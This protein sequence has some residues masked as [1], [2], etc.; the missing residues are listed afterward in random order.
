M[1]ICVYGAASTKIDKK[2]TRATEDL[3]E[4]LALR[5]HTLVFG[6]GDGGVMGAAARG[7]R[8][9]G[10]TVMGVAP[11]FFTNG[12]IEEIYP[13][14]DALVKTDS[15]GTRKTVME[16]NADAFITG[17]GG[18]GTYD[19]FFQVLTLKQLKVFDK[20]IIIFNVAHFYDPIVDLLKKGI[21]EKF[22]RSD[23]LS[24]YKVFTERQM[25]AMAE[26][27]EAYD[28]DYTIANGECVD[29]IYGDK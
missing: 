29:S 7:F 10:G 1:R 3:C 21:E 27:I 5:G 25:D 12:T 20:P 19:E 2:Y 26:F 9:G 6:A 13:G 28:N 8:K 17:P 16:A 22:L 23:T 18:I 14:C 4:K 11:D 15:M 24:L